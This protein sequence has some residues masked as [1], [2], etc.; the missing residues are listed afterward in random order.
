VLFIPAAALNH[1][2]SA[3]GSFQ[4]FARTIEI[5]SSA[6]PQYQGV[7]EG[8]SSPDNEVKPPPTRGGLSGNWRSTKFS[9]KSWNIRE[10][11]FEELEIGNKSSLIKI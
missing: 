11:G 7:V 8:F 2:S 1:T 5:I 10:I 6:I 9:R 4:V 3:T